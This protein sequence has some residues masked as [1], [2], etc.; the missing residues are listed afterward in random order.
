MTDTAAPD[1]APAKPFADTDDARTKAVE[2]AMEAKGEPT[3]ERI[4]V[5]YFGFDEINTVTLPDG[6]SKVMHKTLNEG[7]RRKYQ[8]KANRDVKLQ[9]ATGD[10]FLKT[11]PA[12]D[13]KALLETCIVGWE[14]IRNGKPWPYSATNVA[15]VME[16]FPPK[17]IDIIHK[18]IMVHN[19]WLMGDM[20]IEDIDR[21]METLKEQ[22]ERMVEEEAGKAGSST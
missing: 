1:L 5:D 10:A 13:R 6:I 9:R 14:L 3:T 7:E 15:T 22:R 18:D 2:A 8:T 4:Q 12:E 20:T 19:S 11:A 16:V 21:E 17:I